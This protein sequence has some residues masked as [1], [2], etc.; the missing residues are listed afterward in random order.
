MGHYH[1]ISTAKRSLHFCRVKHNFSV[2]LVALLMVSACT[3]HNN[4]NNLLYFVLAVRV[5]SYQMVCALITHGAVVDQV[6]SKG[7]TAIHEAAR[8]GCTDILML[9]LRRGGHVSVRDINGVTPLG[10]AAE[11]ANLEVL[12]VL[13]ELGED[14]SS[15]KWDQD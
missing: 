8:V 15:H 10:V 13:I 12:Q 4:Y 6:C 11:C 3:F 5:Q 9:L 7:W 2:D 14:L 1:I